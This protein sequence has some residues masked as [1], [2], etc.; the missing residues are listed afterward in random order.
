MAPSPFGVAWERA[1]KPSDG[2]A[3]ERLRLRRSRPGGADASFA[4][5]FATNSPRQR[6]NGSRPDSGIQE[7]NLIR[8]RRPTRSRTSLA[9]QALSFG[10][11]RGVPALDHTAYALI[12]VP[13]PSPGP[14]PT[15][16]SPERSRRPR[17]GARR[18]HRAR[19]AQE[20]RRGDQ[21]DGRVRSRRH[22][23]G[24]APERRRLRAR[25]PRCRQRRHVREQRVQRQH[26]RLELDAGRRDRTLEAATQVTGAAGRGV[27]STR[28]A[29]HLPARRRTADCG[30]TTV[31]REPAV[32]PTP[33]PTASPTAT[34]TATPTVTP[35][36]TP[37]TS[38]VL[39]R[40]TTKIAL[41]R[42]HRL[43]RAVRPHQQGRAA[44]RQ[45][46]RRRRDR[47]AAQGRPPDHLHRH[48]P[49]HRDGAVA[50]EAQGQ[51][52][53]QVPRRA[54]DAAVAHAA[55]QGPGD[56]RPRPTGPPR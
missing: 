42:A 3:P 28:P 14:P 1:L 48:H 25:S 12:P 55:R 2:V 32:I 9:G 4:A 13:T 50:A 11:A 16:V 30:V 39:S 23:S 51:A 56:A 54:E 41:R 15:S 35:T 20:H 38:L 34:P 24:D 8:P 37:A 44:E 53:A 22:R 27:S 29:R 17:A 49:P 19:R 45:V 43:H 21:G 36:P 31:E 46:H 10:T 47:E 40:S 26:R 5:D 18:Q 7:G 52:H 6:P 33:T